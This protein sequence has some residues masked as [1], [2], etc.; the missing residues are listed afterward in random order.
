MAVITLT[1][2]K[3]LLGTPD[4][5]DT[6]LQFYVDAVTPVL[7]YLGCD[8]DTSTAYTDT[9]DGGACQISLP[10][11]PVLTVTSVIESWGA[12]YTQ[13]L[14]ATDLFSGSGSTSAYCYSI[15]LNTGLLTRRAAG[16]AVPFANGT[17]NIQVAWTAGFADP[18]GNV[19]LAALELLRGWWQIAEQGNR[20]A[21]GDAPEMAFAALPG[22]TR[23]RVREMLAGNIRLPGLA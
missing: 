18:P 3:L 21:F 9:F 11:A 4:S 17:R 22:D 8:V 5:K 16:V 1:Q 13:T 6:L 19:V 7:T 10:H 15:E 14:T 2:A 20:P 23:Q 12:N